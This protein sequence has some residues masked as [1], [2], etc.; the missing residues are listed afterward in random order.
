MLAGKV[1]VYGDRKRN[2]VY[3]LPFANESLHDSFN[4]PF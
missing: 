2:I 4:K 1:D 3:A